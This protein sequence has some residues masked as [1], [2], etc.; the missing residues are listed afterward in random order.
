MDANKLKEILDKHLKWLLGENGGSW[1]NLFGADLSGAD[2]SGAALFGADLSGADLSG[3]DLSGANL[4]GADLSGAN[5]SGA[6]LSGADLSGAD[7]SW[8]LWNKTSEE[9]RFFDKN[10]KKRIFCYDETAT[11]RTFVRLRVTKKQGKPCFLLS[12]SVLHLFFL[13]P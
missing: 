6:N 4:S 11:R 10:N 8:V 7:L 9:S 5:L 2:L 12:L 13:S 1:A 3:A